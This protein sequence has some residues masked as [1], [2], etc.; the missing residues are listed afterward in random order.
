MGFFTGLALTK[1]KNWYL[2][3]FYHR[4]GGAGSADEMLLTLGLIA[5]LQYAD[6]EDGI[7]FEGTHYRYYRR[8]LTLLKK[9]VEE[10]KENKVSFVIDLGDT[11]DGKNVNA[12][13]SNSA[14][15]Q[16]LDL[17]GKCQVPVYHLWGNH[18]L[19]NFSQEFL[20]MSALMNPRHLTGDFY[21]NLCSYT[22][23]SP[24]KQLRLVLLDSYDVSVLGRSNDSPSY[25]EAS[26]ILLKNPNKNKNS[27][28]G[29]IGHNIR[30]VMFNGGI[31]MEQ[32]HWLDDLLGKSDKDAEDVLIFGHTALITSDNI[33]LCWNYQEV[34]DVLHSHT[35][36]LAYVSGHVHHFYRYTDFRGI[37]H[38]TMPGV[39]EAFTEAE[40]GHSMID[41][42]EDKI[43]VRGNDLMPEITMTRRNQ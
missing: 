41:V 5:D 27:P 39:V 29:L 26:K 8:S 2:F 25:L 20:R 28:K 11:I 6:I 22:H 10:W 33:C 36:V 7:D 43:V 14:L 31:S 40:S 15:Q 34:L 23:F 16:V 42:Y 9:A 4:M 3:T 30:F 37:H 17:F 13:S 1:C 12:Q 21:D 35:C 32:L 19:Y 18:E 24:C 38:I